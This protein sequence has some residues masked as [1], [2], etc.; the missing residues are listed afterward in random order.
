[1]SRQGFLLALY[2]SWRRYV[3]EQ[4]NIGLSAA[5]HTTCG[6]MSYNTVPWPF[7][8]DFWQRYLLEY[9][10]LDPYIFR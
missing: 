9:F 5:E 2:G 4:G 1:M 3:G 10:K 7:S 6:Q 8:L